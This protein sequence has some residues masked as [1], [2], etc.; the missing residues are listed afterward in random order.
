MKLIQSPAFWLAVIFVA[1]AAIAVGWRMKRRQDAG[2]GDTV[3][4]PQP[5]WGFKDAVK[6]PHEWMEGLNDDDEALSR[7]V[8]AAKAWDDEQVEAA[9]RHFVFDVA[10]SG[11]AW[12]EQQVLKS[13]GTRTHASLMKILADASRRPRLVKPTG[14]NLLP[15]APFNRVCDL[16]EED[17]PAEAVALLVPFLDDQ[18]D[19]IRKSAALLIGKI[20]SDA[21]IAPIRKALADSDEHV[22]AHALFGLGRAKEYRGLSEACRRELFADVQ[23]LILDVENAREAAAVLLDFDQQRA[24]ELF[25][26]DAVFRPDANALQGVLDALNYRGIS[27]PRDHLVRLIEKL[28]ELKQEYP[29]D[30]QLH[31][32][33][34]HL[35]K[36]KN[37]GDR[38]TFERYLSHPNKYTAESAATGVLNLCGLEE[39]QE[40]ISQVIGSRGP[41]ALNV[42]QRRYIAV[43]DFDNEVNNGGL[44]QYFFNS[45]GDD[46]RAAQAGL[47][48]M[49]SK[50]RLAILREALAKFGPA[51]PSED[52]RKRMDQ[53]A[54]LERANDT[55][56]NDLDSRYYECNEVVAVMAMRYVLANAEAFR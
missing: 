9:T 13:L 7:A 25:L 27:V 4:K 46:W 5:E 3:I 33:L 30:W 55:L 21:V 47:E 39:F 49:G 34:L 31:Q 12:G 15:E 56:F 16:L 36:H 28:G 24:M 50:E 26:S 52:H 51:G 17:P 44:T 10:S 35:A 11:K 53:L 20:G 18:S 6:N 38:K 8:E 42:P 29:H 32:A 14:K 40:R 1:A 22:R 45:S 41:N 19:E 54:K 37:P 2:T 48:A 23:R 43:I